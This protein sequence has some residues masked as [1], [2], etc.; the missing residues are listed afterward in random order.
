MRKVLVYKKLYSVPFLPL[1]SH[2][3]SLPLDLESALDSACSVIA[4]SNS[5]TMSR[6][7]SQQARASCSQSNNQLNV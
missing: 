2:L 6:P 7:S 5:S 4:P 3:Y 1:P